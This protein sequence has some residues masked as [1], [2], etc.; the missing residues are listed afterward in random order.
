MKVKE[1]CVVVLFFILLALGYVS[2]DP[3]MMAEGDVHDNR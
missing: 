2:M 1:A 3:T